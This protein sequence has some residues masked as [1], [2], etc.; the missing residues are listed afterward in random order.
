AVH[1]TVVDEKGEP[2]TGGGVLL[3]A[4]SI[5]NEIAG[6]EPL[7]T[8]VPASDGGPAKIEWAE[9][10]ADRIKFL[11]ENMQGHVRFREAHIRKVDPDGKFSFDA[12]E[13]GPH[14]V[15]ARRPDYQTVT[16]LREIGPEPLEWRIRMSRKAEVFLAGRVLG[17]G[18]A[19]LPSAT[20]KAV[21]IPEEEGELGWAVA[22]TTTTAEG[23]YSLRFSGGG[24]F[25]LE[26]RHG[27]RVGYSEPTEG[28]NPALDLRVP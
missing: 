15:F 20:V 11:E 24:R 5:V 13:P 8:V 4:V 1:G 26:A 10:A 9:G 27:G 3:C 18:G 2:L 6:G 25:R 7:I 21:G 19:P 16:F 28:A 23:T 12:V 17:A 22:E 14:L